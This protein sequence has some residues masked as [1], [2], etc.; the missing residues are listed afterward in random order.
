MKFKVGDRVKLPLNETG[1]LVKILDLPWGFDHVVRI[2][3]ATFNKTNEHVEYKQE[4]LEL[5][6]PKYIAFDGGPA[7][8]LRGD[9]YYRD[10]G[11]WSV[12]YKIIDGQLLSWNLGGNI[13]HL[14]KRP[15]IPITKEEWKKC[16][17]RYARD[18]PEE[19]LCPKCNSKI[20]ER[21]SGIRCSN[22]DECGYWYCA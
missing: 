9:K 14:H 4:Q 12:G 15:L 1:T 17:G 8:R 16:N 10:A 7:M 6:L 11:N 18:E 20:I 21:W 2:R 3:K 5:E 22:Y 13:P 19:S